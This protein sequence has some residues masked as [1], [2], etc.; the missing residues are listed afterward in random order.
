M[1]TSAVASRL[2]GIAREPAPLWADANAAAVPD[3]AVARKGRD[4]PPH[5]QSFRR[6]TNAELDGKI[7][8]PNGSSVRADPGE[9]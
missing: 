6:V 1:G 8:A 3:R 5:E 4:G 7:T 2:P 9:G